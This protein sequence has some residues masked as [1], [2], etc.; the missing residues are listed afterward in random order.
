MSLQLQFQIH[1]YG[2]LCGDDLGFR[3]VLHLTNISISRATITYSICTHINNYLV[4][5]TIASVRLNSIHLRSFEY[6][7]NYN[8]ADRLWLW[9]ASCATVS[10]STGCAQDVTKWIGS[11][12]DMLFGPTN[13]FVTANRLNKPDRVS[14]AP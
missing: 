9:T 2:D 10:N 6:F 12:V 1:I 5:S 3:Y 13:P 11:I 8:A 4:L 7:D 14:C